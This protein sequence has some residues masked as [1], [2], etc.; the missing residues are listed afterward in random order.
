MSRDSWAAAVDVQEATTPLV[1]VGLF[2]FEF[3]FK[4]KKKK[5]EHE[6]RPLHPQ[7]S[8]PVSRWS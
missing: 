5:G 1:Q 3:K 8:S 6:R 7:P 2:E 4:F